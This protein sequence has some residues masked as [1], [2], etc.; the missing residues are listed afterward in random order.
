MYI[1]QEGMLNYNLGIVVLNLLSYLSLILYYHLPGWQIYGWML[2]L[3]SG[4]CFLILFYFSL[5]LI[6]KKLYTWNC[7]YIIEVLSLSVHSFDYNLP[8]LK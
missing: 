1:V 5:L 3:S 6:I 2:G 7:H 8:A 4:F